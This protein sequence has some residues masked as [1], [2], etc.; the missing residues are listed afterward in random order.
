[1]GV[2]KRRKVYYYRV[3]VPV[4]VQEQ[5]GKSEVVRTLKTS[6]RSVAD[7]RAAVMA[8]EIERL[9]FGHRQ[10]RFLD[11]EK[12][13][14]LLNAHEA[15]AIRDAREDYETRPPIREHELDRHIENLE[16]VE[17]DLRRALATR[18]Y[19]IIR[20]VVAEFIKNQ[21]L[22]V[23]EGSEDYRIL[24]ANLARMSINLIQIELN[25]AHGIV[26]VEPVTE[27]I[28][29][30]AAV[31]APT[32][33]LL[34]GKA[35]GGAPLSQVIDEF[36]ADASRAW[37][38]KTLQM[39]ESILGLF[40]NIVGDLPMDTIG[41]PELR[42]FKAKLMKLPA[43]LKKQFP[44]KSV[45]QVLAMDVKPMSV[46]SV[47]KYLSAIST[48]F[49][50]AMRHGHVPLNPARELKVKAKRIAHSE[51]PK[52]DLKSMKAIWGD[53][54][55]LQFRLKAPA[56]FWLPLIAAFSG[57]RLEEISQLHRSDLRE[58]DGLWAFDINAK[59]DK[60]LKSA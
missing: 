59:G 26:Q 57:M 10:Q 52:F 14:E 13:R 39:Y 1:M 22:N 33:V 41:F 56:H 31:G 23:L 47:N 53:P 30:A 42:G 5:L 34:A 36:V 38:P 37:S 60:R 6:S 28:A 40:L 51:R 7:E 29:P 24:A 16:Y 19:S 4:D 3:R 32:D 35:E 27:R 54:A 46:R 20:G 18:D 48:L 8:S 50:Y 43:H 44:G 25:H 9:F 49:N 2:F 12:I 45:A 17:T 21:K 15:Q 58:I 55:Y 11:R